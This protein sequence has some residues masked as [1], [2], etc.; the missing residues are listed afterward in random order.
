MRLEPEARA[1]RRAR[2]ARICKRP[3]V[4]PAAI[5]HPWQRRMRHFGGRQH[6]TFV[7]GES[8]RPRARRLRKA[9]RERAA[10]PET[11]A[12]CAY[13]TVMQFDKVLH[14]VQSYAHAVSG[15]SQRRS[16][17]REEAKHCG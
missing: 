9:H 5:L 16:D 17:L 12:I 7:S 6:P 8:K 13:T 15:P 3:R 11:A 4:S 1:T 14:E 2:H 10:V